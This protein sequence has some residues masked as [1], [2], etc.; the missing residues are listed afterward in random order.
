MAD[1]SSYS[2]VPPANKIS[3][4]HYDNCDIPSEWLSNFYRSSHEWP[5]NATRNMILAGYNR[6]WIDNNITPPKPREVEDWYFNATFINK[7]KQPRNA[8]VDSTF[9]NCLDQFCSLLPWKGNAD[10]AGRGMLATYATEAIFTTLYITILLIGQ[11][12]RRPKSGTWKNRLGRIH[13]ATNESLRPFLDAALLLTIAM[14]VAANYNFGIT[15]YD[16]T[17]AVTSTSCVMSA[18]VSL[19]TI[20]PT[21]ALH[22]SASHSLRRS[23]FRTWTWGL[24][25]ALTASMMGLFIWAIYITGISRRYYYDGLGLDTSGQLFF[26]RNCLN[27]DALIEFDNS[28][29]ILFAIL[30]LVVLV[31]LLLRCLW[32]RPFSKK[33]RFL[34]KLR[35]IWPLLTVLWAVLAMWASFGVFVYYRK[36]LDSRA[37]DMSEDHEWSFGQILAI[38]TFAPVVI[39]WTSIWWEGAEEGLNGLMSDQYKV[40]RNDALPQVEET[41][42][43]IKA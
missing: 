10:F 19:F 39:E 9:A 2:W 21:I 41:H 15:I 33:N 42:A 37:G 24:I 14:L 28:L 43:E 36:N 22:T 34:L 38:F 18:F 17:K 23:K 40:Y 30:G 27:M 12:G 8:L 32:R 25:G 13:E 3:S 7:E 31:Y 35:L 5:M 20:F 16:P 26:E 11:Y 29:L 6:Y 1:I 4:L